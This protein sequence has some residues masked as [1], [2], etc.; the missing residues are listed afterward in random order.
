MQFERAAEED[1]R[2]DGESGI[3]TR[4][5]SF[6]DNQ[7][8]TVSVLLP[9]CK[10]IFARSWIKN[11]S[12]KFGGRFGNYRCFQNIWPDFSKYMARQV[13]RSEHASRRVWS[14]RRRQRR[15][16]GVTRGITTWSPRGVDGDHA[17]YDGI[18]PATQVGRRGVEAGLRGHDDG[19]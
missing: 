1:E 8:S 10:F 2:D 4:L 16:V 11:T 17:G 14:T 18:R 19:V 7:K 13:R 3:V 6:R 5:P 15:H 9:S 12:I